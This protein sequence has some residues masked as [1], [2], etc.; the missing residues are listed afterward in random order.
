MCLGWVWGSESNGGAL[1]AF[2]RGF[3]TGSV[4]GLSPFLLTPDALRLRVTS[5]YPAL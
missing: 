1:N 2:L 3:Y 5:P 4:G